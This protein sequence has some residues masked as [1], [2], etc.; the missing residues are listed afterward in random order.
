[1]S[2]HTGKIKNQGTKSWIISPSFS[3]ILIPS[4]EEVA[5]LVRRPVA[6]QFPG[7]TY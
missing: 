5:F 2:V 4:G 1:M 6:S 7:R 3:A